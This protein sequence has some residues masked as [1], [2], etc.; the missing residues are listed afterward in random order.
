MRIFG[1]FLQKI[2]LQDKL[3]FLALPILSFGPMLLYFALFRKIKV[4]LNSLIKS[5]ILIFL[6]VFIFL[7]VLQPV[8]SG[9]EITN[10]NIIRLTTLAFIP[11]LILLILITE[12]K[13]N[14]YLSSKMIVYLFY[15]I[16]ITQSL[17]PTFS[18]IQVFDILKF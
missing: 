7:V 18:K 1:L 12:K 4:K 5:K 11:L 16:T 14:K 17:H 13:N 10:R 6:S 8:L 15:L 2:S 3:L 9:P